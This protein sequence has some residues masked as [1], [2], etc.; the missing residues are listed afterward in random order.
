MDGIWARDS[1]CLPRVLKQVLQGLVMLWGLLVLVMAWFIGVSRYTDHR[2]NI[3]D[4]LVSA[5]GCTA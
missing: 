4:I 1:R 3:D 5:G 2:H